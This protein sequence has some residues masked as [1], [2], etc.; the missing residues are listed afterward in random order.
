VP[1]VGG[2]RTPIDALNPY[3]L[4]RLEGWTAR[5]DCVCLRRLAQSLTGERGRVA[6]DVWQAGAHAVRVSAHGYE[7]AESDVFRVA[8][9]KGPQELDV[10]VELWPRR[11]KCVMILSDVSRAEEDVRQQ[12]GGE[13][14]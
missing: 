13:S 6:L 11:V 7:P 10:T 1:E 14:G 5:E 12:L 8:A 4:A 2:L 3:R 9:G